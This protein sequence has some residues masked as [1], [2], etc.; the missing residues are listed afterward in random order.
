MMEEKKY[1]IPLHEN[2]VKTEWTI[3]GIIG[4]D[5]YMELMKLGNGKELPAFVN[6]KVSKES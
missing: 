1:S 3:D 6:V 2:G 4:D 5:K